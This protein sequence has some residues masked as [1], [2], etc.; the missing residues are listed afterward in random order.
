MIRKNREIKQS[1]CNGRVL[2]QSQRYKVLRSGKERDCRRHPFPC[3]PVQVIL[4]VHF[5]GGG[6]AGEEAGYLSFALSWLAKANLAAFSWSLANLFSYL[7]T[8]LRVGLM[9]LPFMSDTDMLSSLM[10]RS[11]RMTSRCRKNIS[12][13]RLYHL[14]KS[15][16]QIFFRSSMEALSMSALVPHLSAMTRSLSSALRSCSFFSSSAAFLRRRVL[17]FFFLS[18]VINPFFLAMME[19][20]LGRDTAQE[21]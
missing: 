12:P 7:E 13:S 4:I 16:V 11:R 18:G 2:H 10:L 15:S 17:S 9:N 20:V 21:H 14:S 5:H 6:G 19:S 3:A 1:A 8:F